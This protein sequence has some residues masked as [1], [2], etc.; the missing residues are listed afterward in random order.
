MNNLIKRINNVR[1]DLV[2]FSARY[3]PL[4]N[5]IKAA[6]VYHKLKQN[7]FKN[8][9]FETI[10]EAQLPDPNI[11]HLHEIDVS[12]PFLYRQGIWKDTFKRLRLEAPIHYQHHS[13]FGPFW[14]MTQYEDVM[15]VDKNH[16][17]FSSEPIIMLG[18]QPQGLELEMFIAMDPPKHDH[19]RKAVQGVFV[20]KNLKDMENLIRTR[21]QDVLDHLPVNEPFD[22]V[23]RVSI[24]LTSR[25]LATLLDFP[26]E[27][28][29]KLVYWS[30]IASSTPGTTGG[31]MTLEDTFEGL[32]DM[33][34]ELSN[35]WYAKSAKIEAGEEPSFDLMSLLIR[36]EAT[37]DIIK[38]P[39]EFLG[40]LALLI[41]GGNDT[42]RNSMTGGIYAMHL[43]PK[44]LDKIKNNRDLMPNMVSEI[45]RWQTPLAYMR[46][47][48]TQDLIYKGQYIRKGDKVV[49]WYASANRDEKVFE[50]ADEF[51][52]DRENVKKH[53]S[54]G[55]G[56]HRCMGSRLAE[57]QLTILWEE[58]LQRYDRIEVLEDPAIVQSNFVRGYS[59]MMVEI[60]P[61]T[62]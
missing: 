18:E 13:L 49:M 32:K 51:L 12:S 46:R 8:P 36:S 41:V 50:N 60:H 55:Y 4:E 62:K 27:E 58:I 26:Y 53:L 44:E 43:Y 59:K 6:H 19:Q 52:I 57:M 9:D 56:I 61:L 23:E 40:N 10:Q 20:P 33:V 30:E 14:S 54:F 37:K 2:N 39:L 31:A 16:Q 35:L 45:I 1:I 21:T 5:H 47:V 7:L 17:L 28:R 34:R 29:R 48:A 15:Y 22:F 24:E 11:C 25:M 3:I 42:T 38:R